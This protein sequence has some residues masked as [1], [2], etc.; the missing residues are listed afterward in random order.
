MKVRFLAAAL[1][2][3]VVPPAAAQAQPVAPPSDFPAVYAQVTAPAT[4]GPVVCTAREC[5]PA[6]GAAGG[7][8][9]SACAGGSCRPAPTYRFA[10]FGGRFRR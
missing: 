7:P 4:A 8:G 6:A 10:P 9:P 5:V 2:A 1:A 3:A